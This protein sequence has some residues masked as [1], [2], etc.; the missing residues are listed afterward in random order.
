MTEAYSG[1][2]WIFCS[3]P[4]PRSVFTEPYRSFLATLVALRSEQG[5]SQVELARRLGKPQ[6]FVSRYELGVRRLDLVEFYVIARALEVLRLEQQLAT[7]PEPRNRIE[8]FQDMVSFSKYGAKWFQD[9]DGRVKRLIAEMVGSN[10][11]LTDKILRIQAVKPFLA[12]PFSP[13]FLRQ[14]G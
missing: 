14:C 13:D 3:Q 7:P 12:P 6:Q 8:L 2:G 10:F 9:G 5:V 1:F 11:F 4:M